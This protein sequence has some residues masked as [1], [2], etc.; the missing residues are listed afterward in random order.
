MKDKELIKHV[1]LSAIKELNHSD[2]NICQSL[3]SVRFKI[4][5]VLNLLDCEI[6]KQNTTKLNKV[7]IKEPRLSM[8]AV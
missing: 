5:M 1:L 4:C 3:K 6:E 7:E 2:G 8:E